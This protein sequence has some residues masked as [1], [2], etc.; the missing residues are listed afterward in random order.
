VE[1]GS[2]FEAHRYGAQLG[3]PQQVNPVVERGMGVRLADEDEMKVVQ[4]GAPAKGLVGV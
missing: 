1:V 2:D 4:E 3:P